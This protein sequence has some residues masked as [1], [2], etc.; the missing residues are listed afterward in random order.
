[1]NTFFSVSN[2]DLKRLTPDDAADVFR[3]LLWAEATSS[4]IG[5]NLIN[6]PSAIT[7][8]DGGIDA[9]VRDVKEDSTRGIIKAGLTRY[10]IK[11]GNISLTESS[12]KDILLKEK[13][14]EIKPKIKSC[15]DKDG[16]L[17]IV[18]FGSDNPETK[19]NQLIDICKKV[20]SQIDSK[21]SN[22]KIEIWRQNNIIGYLRDFPSLALHVNGRDKQSFQT[23]RSWSRQDDMDRELKTGKEQE[24]FITNLQ[25]ELRRCDE[26]IHIRIYGEPGIG[27]TR[28]VLEATKVD[29]LMPLVI[30]C[31]AA[32]KFRDSSLMNDILKDDSNFS[33]LL[34]LDECDSDSRAYIWNKLKN[35]GSRIKLV[36]IFN[37]LETTSGSIK[38]FD[39]P[40]LNDLQIREVIESY[41]IPKDQAERWSDLCSGSPRV[42]HV[43]G[44]N[45]K[46]NPDDLLR[47]PGTVDV[48]RR[49]VAGSDD[50][51]S[52]DVRDRYI[53]LKHIAL[54]KRFGYGT[55]VINEAQTIAAIIRK[56]FQHITWPRFQEIIMHLK[57]HKIL[58]GENTLYITP[59]ALHIKLWIDW[60][61][62]YGPGFDL[63]S[64]TETLTEELK[65]WFF[66]MFEYAAASPIAQKIVKDLLSENG[67]FHD[68][69]YLKKKLGA[70]FFSALSKA[71][72][73]SALNFLKRTIGKWDNAERLQFTDGRREVVWALER[74]AILKECFSDAARLLLALGEAENE[75]FSN[76]A[77][78]VFTELFSLGYGQVASTEVPPHERLPILKEALESNSNK[79]QLLA[80]RA[81]DHALESEHWS[82]MV[83]GRYGLNREPILWIPKTYGELYDAFREVWQLLWQ[84]VDNLPY[85][86]QQETVNVFLNRA[87]GLG[88][89]EYLVDMVIDTLTEL[90]EKSYVN[91]KTVLYHVIEILHYEGKDLPERIKKRWEDLK[92]RLTGN[93]YSALMKRYIGM[94]LLTDKFDENGE[95]EDKTKPIIKKLAEDAAKD[96]NLLIPELIW[97]VTAEAK[98]GHIFGYELGKSDV[99]FKA[100][101]L[102]LEAQKN[103]S[104]LSAYFIGGYF[105]A[106]NERDR[107]KWETELDKLMTEPSFSILIPEITWRSGLTNQAALRILKLAETSKIR[108]D[109]FRLFAYGGVIRKLSEDVF[110]LWVE[111]LLNSSQNYSL[112]IA[113]DLHFF[114]YVYSKVTLPEQLTFRLLT[115]DRL[116]RKRET[117]KHHN[118]DDYHWTV[119]AKAFV[120]AYPAKSLK[121]AEI[122]IEHFGEKGTIIEN[123]YSQT[124]EVI[125]LIARQHPKKVWQI[126]IHYLGP[127]LDSRAFHIRH[128]LRGGDHHKEKEGALTFFSPE[129]IWEWVDVDINNRAPYLANFVPATLFKEGNK[130]CLTREVLARY[131]SD[132]H[133]RDNIMANFSTEIWSGPE[134]LHIQNK[135]ER[136][137]AFKNKETDNNVRLWI[138]EYVY[139]LNA[140]IER[141]KIEEEREGF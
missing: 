96:I 70:N 87:R 52:D 77:S 78:G 80:I 140:R 112:S 106:I 33:V 82:R 18:L 64:F 69:E 53:V 117:K 5:V 73:I 39:V 93:G 105:N 16:T 9:E 97:L 84:K 81:C 110:N 137:L 118:M 79:R 27:K 56:G 125:N 109:S 57:S 135:K 67:P 102:I 122:M 129:L 45:L 28:L 98:N 131:G 17:V 32:D 48:W 24:A 95:L 120:A 119:T 15:L 40:S 3:E 30:Y 43:I 58:Q 136:L 111:F 38:Y 85:D 68:Q 59:K 107:D 99:E 91:K 86:L 47:T 123:Y 88:K 115:D 49:Y 72:P 100:L 21:Y 61:D 37:E 54:F 76:N 8:A 13:S 138:D 25:T 101:P 35:S 55:R 139:D 22:A 75:T 31:D 19:D 60:W 34:V 6:V 121:I 50:Q 14:T 127:P 26:A 90:G 20:L 65:E 116:F 89:F 7:V 41:N 11:A 51:D 46:N 132:K 63:K 36:T 44:L 113:L 62:T 4:K 114:Y 103:T 29:D 23:L 74:I 141:A 83:I 10:Q 66:E 104:D 124:H 128:W 130:I 92:D 12:A 71:D 134:S 126:I 42:A 94:D 108:I 133:V 2:D 1:M